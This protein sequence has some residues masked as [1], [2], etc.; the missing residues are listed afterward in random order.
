M[1]LAYFDDYKFGVVTGDAV[2]DVSS[3]VQSVP[4]TGPH[5]LINGVIARFAEYRPRLEEAARRGKPPYPALAREN[6]WTGDVV[7]EIVLRADGRAELGLRRSSGHSVLDQLAARDHERVGQQHLAQLGLVA[8]AGQVH[9]P[10]PACDELAVRQQ[11]GV[12]RGG[13][14][15]RERVGDALDLPRGARSVERGHTRL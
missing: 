4:H 7:L 6:N 1:K 3:A 10:A 13:Q 15:D 5:D 11:S 9:A 2:V 8:R 12:R 14:R